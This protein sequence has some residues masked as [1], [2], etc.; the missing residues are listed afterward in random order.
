[1]TIKFHYMYSGRIKLLD[2]SGSFS[3]NKGITSH[4]HWVVYVVS[5][6][7]LALCHYF[8]SG[9]SAA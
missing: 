6:F 2:L 4:H 8:S 7:H 1:M 5:C 9:K 3:S